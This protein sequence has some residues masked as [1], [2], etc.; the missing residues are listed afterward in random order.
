MWYML[1]YH[2]LSSQEVLK[3]L[4]TTDKGLSEKQVNDRLL[5]FGKN[6]LPSKKGINPVLLFLKQ[7]NNLLIYVLLIAATISLIFDHPADTIIILIV[8]LLNAIIGFT[9]ESAAEKSISALK[10]LLVPIAKVIRSGKQQIISATDLVPGDIVILE[11]GDKVPADGR[12]LEVRGLK[13]IESSLTGESFAVSKNIDILD[14]KTG[15]ADRTNM[16]FMSTF[17]SS[18]S[19]K[20]VVIGT[21]IETQIGQIAT[22]ISEIKN[23]KSQFLEN[24]SRLTLQIGTLSL[25]TSTFIFIISYFV[26]GNELIEVFL[27]TVAALVSGIPEGLPAI[28]T[29]VL[30]IGAN[31]MASKKAI[32]RSLPAIETLG[33]VTTICT[34]KTGTLTENTMTVEKAYLT[35]GIELE[36]AGKGWES[37]GNILQSKKVVKFGDNQELDRLLLISNFGVQATV[38]KKD[39]DF[40]IIGDPTEAGIKVFAQ[41][42]DFNKTNFKLLDDLPFSSDT[43]YRASLIQFPDNSKKIF[44]IGAPDILLK[45]SSFGFNGGNINPLEKLHFDKI[46]AQIHDYNKQGSR[47]IAASFVE[48]DKKTTQIDPKLIQN[49]VMVGILAINDPVREG[50]KEAVLQAKAAGIRVVMMTGDH[51]ITAGSIAKKIGI[52]DEN[53]SLDDKSKTLTQLELEALSPIEFVE[54]VK[55]VNVF[56]RL[57]PKMKLEITTELQKQ[58]QI[59]AMTGDGVNDAPALKKADVGISMGK[60]GTDV[61]R[62]ASSMVLVDDNFVTIVAAVEQGRVVFSNIKRSVYYLI[63]TNIAESVTI[64]AALILSL[65]APLVAS[66]ILW[67]NLVTDGVNGIAIATEKENGEEL[68]QK[69]R[70]KKE[71]ILTKSVLPYILSISTIMMVFSLLAFQY[72]LPTSESKARTAVLIVMSFTQLFNVLNM[73]SLTQSSFKVGIFGNKYVNFGVAFSTFLIILSVYWSPLALGL[74]HAP[75]MP[76]EFAVLVLISSTSLWFGEIYKKFVVKT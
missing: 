24:T 56:A 55:N 9:Q 68:K 20:M 22:E 76:L 58:G 41:K 37:V 32:I 75:L 48:V 63:S 62:E 18:G 4:E 69:P 13:V 39:G 26:R 36:V 45:L 25:I 19:A 57:T 5:E 10:N 31:R 6:I 27:F 12:L 73:R 17:V 66:Q 34:D 71:G 33:S 60:I 2:H 46:Q 70:P 59:V 44:V 11:E 14:Q 3:K 54:A 38:N 8:V 35:S 1:D 74:K 64:L 29:I 16:V 53:Y 30:A 49:L 23:E 21:G 40:Q 52:L 15:V 50:V 28:L 61:A 51:R 67:M 42:A 7:F 72:F 43:K 65:P 47:T